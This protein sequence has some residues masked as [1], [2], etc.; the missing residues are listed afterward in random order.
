MTKLWE[1]VA[2]AAG[3]RLLAVEG[4]QEL[5]HVTTHAKVCALWKAA[6]LQQVLPGT[7]RGSPCSVV[8]WVAVGPGAYHHT[9]HN[10]L[11]VLRGQCS[12]VP[13]CK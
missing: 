2:T 11:T 3:D 6:A 9:C 10:L 8:A 5:E 7:A 1:N 12:T 13:G 4:P